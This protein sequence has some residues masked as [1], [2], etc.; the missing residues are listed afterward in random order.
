VRFTDRLRAS[1]RVATA[2]AL[3]GALSLGAAAAATAATPGTTT[4]TD[5]TTSGSA[6]HESDLRR[7]GRF[8]ARLAARADHRQ[9]PAPPTPARRRC[10]RRQRVLLRPQARRGATIEVASV[11][12]NA[13]PSGVG[14]G[15]SQLQSAYNL[16]SA[17]A[18][19]GA[20]RTVALVDAYDDPTA[21]ADLAAY[22]SAAGL[23][24]ATFKKV[25]QEG[26]TSPLPS[27]APSSRRLD[28]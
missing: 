11:S 20:G 25:N 8:R 22:R 6:A 18:A 15:P 19:D 1:T 14:F 7:G 9:Q 21:A 26:A 4:A 28:A 12:P 23:P 27:E 24:T 3:G 13:I 2:V 17:S 10:G 16:T 5:A